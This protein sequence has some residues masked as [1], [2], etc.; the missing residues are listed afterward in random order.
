MQSYEPFKQMKWL[1]QLEKQEDPAWL[2]APLW[3]RKL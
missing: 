3:S 1:L 2:F